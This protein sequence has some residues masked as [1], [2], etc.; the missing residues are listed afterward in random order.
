MAST[1]KPLRRVKKSKFVGPGR[2][3]TKECRVY[4]A[5]T[6]DFK[7]V[8]PGQKLYKGEAKMRKLLDVTLPED[9]FINNARPD[10]LKNPATNT[11]MELDRY[12]P[13]AAI[14]FEFQGEQH[15]QFV[16]KFHKSKQ[17]FESQVK[18]D[19][20]KVRLCKENKVSLC[21]VH[22]ADLSQAKINKLVNKL[23]RLQDKYGVTA[24]TRAVK[25]KRKRKKKRKGRIVF[26]VRKGSKQGWKT[27]SEHH[28]YKG[29]RLRA[30]EMVGIDNPYIESTHH[31][32]NKYFMEFYGDQQ[33]SHPWVCMV[34]K[35]RKL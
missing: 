27:D 13:D 10:W 34:E 20:A 18:R 15:Y 8:E 9:R 28:T 3:K 25:P 5:G 29:A 16:Q 30:I 7:R 32:T 35:T 2:P 14:A 1:V 21:Y 33:M 17:Q 12:Y 24:I 6:G 4:D 23:F 11:V 26:A 19:K 31:H 22:Q